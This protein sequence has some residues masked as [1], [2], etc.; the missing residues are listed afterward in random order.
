VPIVGQHLLLFKRIEPFEG[1]TWLLRIMVLVYHHLR[2]WV[3]NMLNMLR[4]AVLRWWR[5]VLRLLDMVWVE[6]LRVLSV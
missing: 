4:I 1:A 6:V 3:L 5:I 2:W